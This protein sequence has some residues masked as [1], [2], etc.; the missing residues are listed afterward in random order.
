MSKQED[1]RDRL[2]GM[3]DE[4][5]WLKNNLVIG[6]TYDL[7]PGECHKCDKWTAPDSHCSCGRFPVFPIMDLTWKNEPFL[8]FA[9]GSPE[10]WVMEEIYAEAEQY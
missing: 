6:K 10:D 8:N 3:S 7:E 9:I 2:A 5:I 4:E 1:F